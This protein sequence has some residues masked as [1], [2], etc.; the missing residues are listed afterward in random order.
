MPTTTTPPKPYSF[1]RESLDQI[2][3]YLTKKNLVPEKFRDTDKFV[4]VVSWNLRWF[5][6]RDPR[7]V[8]AITEIMAEMNSDVFVLTEVAEDGALKQVVDALAERRAGFYSTAYGTTGGQQRVVL[9]WDRDWIRAKRDPVEL[10]KNEDLVVSSDG[11]LKADVFPRLPLWCYYEAFP[12]DETTG[13]EGFNFELVGVHMKSQMAP[14]GAD[15]KRGGIPQRTKGAERLATWLKTPHEHYDEDVI[16]VGD[17]N[18]KPSEKEW[19]ALRKLEEKG[20]IAFTKINREEE[21]S[22]IARFNKSGPGGTRLDL[23]L[24]N[25]RAMVAAVPKGTGV[26]IRW[27]LFD[28]L[29]VMES[30]KREQ[31]FKNFTHL[32]SDHL[33]VLSRFYT[34][35]KDN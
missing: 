4:D 27:S 10:F 14:R 20:E 26:V 17:W 32:I 16:L 28:D 33:P 9:M 6:H 35:D 34:V 30:E 29:S 1:D 8:E 31:L 7:R 2:S 12:S 15:V 24:V 22:H 11:E 13:D 21:I 18:A 23:Q 25:R 3:R 19:N 5:D